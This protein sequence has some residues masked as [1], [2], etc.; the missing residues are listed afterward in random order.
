M[1]TKEQL[2]DELGERVTEL[3]VMMD[4]MKWVPSML[5]DVKGDDFG[6]TLLTFYLML[7]HDIAKMSAK[8][9][10]S[11]FGKTEK[12]NI[13]EDDWNRISN[14]WSAAMVPITNHLM[15]LQVNLILQISSWS[16]KEGKKAAQDRLDA[17]LSGYQKFFEYHM[18]KF[19][20]GTRSDMEAALAW[21]DAVPFMGDYRQYPKCNWWEIMWRHAGCAEREIGEGFHKEHCF[22]ITRGK[23]CKFA[24]WDDACGLASCTYKSNKVACHHWDMHTPSISNACT[25]SDM[26]GF[27]DNH[28]VTH[29]GKQRKMA[30]AMYKQS[31]RYLD[32]P[33]KH[34]DDRLSVHVGMCR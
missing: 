31:T 30:E 24:Q 6:H 25:K 32:E 26:L 8:I 13:G 12:Q 16:G 29:L 20:D 2:K 18:P 4:E 17:I 22:W 21:N 27:W 3:T 1:I 19:E 7:Q 11:N 33:L 23:G 34:R 28:V 15:S 5:S 14:Q 10:R 9:Q